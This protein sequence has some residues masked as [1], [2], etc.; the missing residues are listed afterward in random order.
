MKIPTRL[1]PENAEQK[2]YKLQWQGTFGKTTLETFL[3][4]KEVVKISKF[5]VLCERI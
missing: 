4:E 1:R 2:A 5:G 3:T